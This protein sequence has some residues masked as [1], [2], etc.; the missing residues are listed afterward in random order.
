MIIV[1]PHPR[2]INSI[3]EVVVVV[4]V[5]MTIQTEHGNRA[6]KLKWP[7]LVW[8]CPWDA[9]A[10]LV[11]PTRTFLGAQHWETRPSLKQLATPGCFARCVIIVTADL[12]LKRHAISTHDADSIQVVPRQFYEM[13]DCNL[14]TPELNKIA[15]SKR[16]LGCA[17]AMLFFY[18]G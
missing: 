13:V 6:D 7:E 9:S 15:S 5:C 4:V 17:S 16:K 12:P 2:G 3:C 11:G 14:N 8:S 1:H 18:R 10:L